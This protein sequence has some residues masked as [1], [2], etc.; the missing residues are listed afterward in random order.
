MSINHARAKKVSF[1]DSSLKAAFEDLKKGKHE[2]RE[3]VVFIQRAVEDLQ[4]NP[5]CGV[6][7]PSKLWPKEYIQKYKIDNLRKYNLPNAW[8]LIYTLKGNEIEIISVIIEWFSHK[9]YERRFKY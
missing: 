8:R 1:V 9:E 2:E 6:R 3:L 4:K 7:I 5:L